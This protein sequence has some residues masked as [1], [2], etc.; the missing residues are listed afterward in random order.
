MHPITPQP[1]PEQPHR[2]TRRDRLRTTRIIDYD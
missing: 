1:T 2:R